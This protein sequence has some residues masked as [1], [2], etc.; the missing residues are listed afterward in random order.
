MSLFFINETNQ[1]TDYRGLC[2]AFPNNYIPPDIGEERLSDWGVV[3]LSETPSPIPAWHQIAYVSGK[4]EQNEVVWS[5]RDKTPEELSESETLAQ[6]KTR[7]YAEAYSLTAS[8]CSIL[9]DSYPQNETATWPSM[10]KDIAAYNLS[11]GSDI[12]STLQFVI[13]RKYE[14]CG[15]AQAK[16]QIAAALS[17]KLTPIIEY[18]NAILA[19]RDFL[20]FSIA[21]ANTEDEAWA[22]DTRAG[23]PTYGA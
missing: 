1:I 22:I 18:E 17:A 3:R 14:A 11:A 5:L 21:S 16:E 20:N 13:D 9:T 23:W 12:G 19:H 4:S 2:A 15:H 10:K 7:K 8:K 6:I